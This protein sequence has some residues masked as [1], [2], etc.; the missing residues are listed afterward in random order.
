[1]YAKELP[2]FAYKENQKQKNR[3]A[4]C[5]YPWL[6]KPLASNS[7]KTI[8]HFIII[9]TFMLCL[10]N[11][12]AQQDPLY[13]HYMYNTL[14]FNPAYAGSRDAMSFFGLARFQW[15]GINGAPMT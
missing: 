6:I 2:L 5:F 15:A 12:R 3:G 9:T 10:T 14:A 1:M 13:T 11:V 8:R 7:M 4:I